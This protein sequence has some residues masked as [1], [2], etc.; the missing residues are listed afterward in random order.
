MSQPLLNPQ[1]RTI[2][3]R[4]RDVGITKKRYRKLEKRA[5]RLNR[6]AS[7]KNS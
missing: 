6:E 7:N 3:E 4:C 5:K 2:K 1:R